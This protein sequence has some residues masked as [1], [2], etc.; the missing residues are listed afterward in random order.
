[1][2]NGVA[3]EGAR[4]AGSIDIAANVDN[5]F[6]KFAESLGT[7]LVKPQVLSSPLAQCFVMFNTAWVTTSVAPVAAAGVIGQPLGRAMIATACSHASFAAIKFTLAMLA[8]AKLP[9]MPSAP[10]IDPSRPRRLPPTGPPQLR[11]R[12]TRK[13]S[14]GG[15]SPRITFPPKRA[16][17]SPRGDARS[18]TA[19]GGSNHSN[20]GRIRVLR[21]PKSVPRTWIV[22]ITALGGPA[23]GAVASAVTHRRR[24]IAVRSALTSLYRGSV[25]GTLLAGSLCYSGAGTSFAARW[26]VSQGIFGALF[27]GLLSPSA[28][29]F[30]FLCNYY[31]MVAG[32]AR[33]RGPRNRGGR[34]GGGT[35]GGARGRQGQEEKGSSSENTKADEKNS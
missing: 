5:A 13:S 18:S 14:I 31:A 29:M 25:L 8:I 2:A 19:T 24:T 15:R 26:A 34:G 27:A 9:T 30:A 7:V 32:K 28:L 4:A 17:A 35:G 20:H 16:R 6:Y 1:M 21:S 11:G 22:V 12:R 23:M 33:R 3:Q 10:P